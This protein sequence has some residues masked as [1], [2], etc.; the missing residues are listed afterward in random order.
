MSCVR[1]PLPCLQTTSNMANLH[2]HVPSVAAFVTDVTEMVARVM[3]SSPLAGV[4]VF[5][6][7]FHKHGDQCSPP[8]LPPQAASLRAGR[9]AEKL[10]CV[11]LLMGTIPRALSTPSTG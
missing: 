10:L 7:Q 1:V 6:P 11:F 9:D 3:I 5:L 2:R 4:N 8:P